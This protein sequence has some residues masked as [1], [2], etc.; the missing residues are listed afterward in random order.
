MVGRAKADFGANSADF[1]AN[2]KEHSYALNGSRV[3]LVAGQAV[4]T[5]FMALSV[6]ERRNVSDKIHE[7]ASQSDDYCFG[8]YRRHDRMD[9]LIEE[10]DIDGSAVW[11]RSLMAIEEPQRVSSPKR[12]REPVAKNQMTAHALAYDLP[13]SWGRWHCPRYSHTA[14]QLQGG[15]RQDWHQRSDIQMKRPSDRP[16]ACRSPISRDGGPSPALAAGEVEPDECQRLTTH[17]LHK[18]R[19][20]N[21]GPITGPKNFRSPSGIRPGPSYPAR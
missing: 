11:R 16:R 21:R 10:G 15:A 2:S 4:V 8:H 7:T 13:I 20:R 9:L 12:S 1:G 18:I 3:V 5:S 14:D 6:L 19:L 17:S